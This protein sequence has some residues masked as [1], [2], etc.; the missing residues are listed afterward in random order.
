MLAHNNLR[1]DRC[2]N[3]DRTAINFSNFEDRFR[4]H[5]SYSSVVNINAVYSMDIKDC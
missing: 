5:A 3:W 2:T 1:D 4:R